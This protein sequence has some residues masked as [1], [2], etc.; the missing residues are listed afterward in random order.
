MQVPQNNIT[1]S[2]TLGS[3]KI[4]NYLKI[5][6]Y[7]KQRRIMARKKFKLR[8]PLQL[9]ESH[10]WPHSNGGARAINYVYSH[11]TH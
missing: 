7:V 5:V 2:L 9:G 10:P 3:S 6:W 4:L 11:W 8:Q 1:K